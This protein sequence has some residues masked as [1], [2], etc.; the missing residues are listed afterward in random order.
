VASIIFATYGT[1]SDRGDQHTKHSRLAPPFPRKMT[2]QGRPRLVTRVKTGQG[3]FILRLRVGKEN[4][5]KL[6][7]ARE[8]RKRPALLGRPSTHGMRLRSRTGRIFQQLPPELKI[9]IFERTAIGRSILL[10][11]PKAGGFKWTDMPQ[12]KKN[13]NDKLHTRHL[14]SA[15]HQATRLSYAERFAHKAPTT[16]I[17]RTVEHTDS[18]Q[19]SDGTGR[20]LRLIFVAKHEEISVPKV[21][22]MEKYLLFSSKHDVIIYQGCHNW[23]RGR[24][25]AEDFSAEDRAAVQELAIQMED[26]EIAAM[27]KVPPSYKSVT[28][29]WPNIKTLYYIKNYVDTFGGRRN[30]FAAPK[31]P[32]AVSWALLRAMEDEDDEELRKEFEKWKAGEEGQKVKLQQIVFVVV[33]AK[34]AAGYNGILTNLRATGMDEDI[35]IG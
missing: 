6:A 34:K 13:I 31:P 27:P 24:H 32:Q 29:S 5:S 9:A 2:T 18:I 8:R 16:Q 30:Y 22:P 35:I 25:C 11:N 17:R 33:T 19:S 15:S 1:V 26:R 21:T 7:T 3:K 14:C 28:F 20:A 4:A 10:P 12:Y 23:C